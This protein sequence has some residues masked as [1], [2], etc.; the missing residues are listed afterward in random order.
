M[1]S[2]WRHPHLDVLGI[3][4]GV[5][6]QQQAD[7]GGVAGQHGPVQRRVLVVLVTQVHRHV[8]RQEQPGGIHT[9]GGK[10]DYS[11]EG[12]TKG[13]YSLNTYTHRQHGGHS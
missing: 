1:A 3:Y 6:L 10:A 13:S 8:E 12:D 4:V 2:R 11:G 9:D 7:D 5:G